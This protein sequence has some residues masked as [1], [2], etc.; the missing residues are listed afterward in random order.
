M[1]HVSTPIECGFSLTLGDR[2]ARGLRVLV[3]RQA[4]STR[5]RSSAKL[6]RPYMVRFTSL[7][8]FAWPSTCPLRHGMS[9]TISRCTEMAI[10]R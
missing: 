9:M 2:V 1:A 5:H 3:S 7:R 6:A 10:I 8:R 4:T